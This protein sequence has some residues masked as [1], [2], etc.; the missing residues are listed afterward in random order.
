MVS[1]KLMA[2]KAF[3]SAREKLKFVEGTTQQV[4]TFRM[5]LR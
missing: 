1:S 2:V 4:K 5:E 3:E